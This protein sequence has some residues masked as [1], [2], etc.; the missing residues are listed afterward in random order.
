MSHQFIYQQQ[1][2]RQNLLGEN[3][4]LQMETRA[5]SRFAYPPLDSIG[6]CLERF[7][8]MVRICLGHGTKYLKRIVSNHGNRATCSESRTMHHI[9]ESAYA[10]D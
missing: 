10:E 1:R 2:V 8:N 9:A 3:S 6:D 5:G 7:D 4:W